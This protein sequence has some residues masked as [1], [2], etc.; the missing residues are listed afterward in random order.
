MTDRLPDHGIC[1]SRRCGAVAA[2]PVRARREGII[3]LSDTAVAT[4]AIA[5]SDP[6]RSP[7]ESTPDTLLHTAA[8][9][10]VREGQMQVGLDAGHTAVRAVGRVAHRST[11]VESRRAPR[12]RE[13]A[14]RPEA[15]VSRNSCKARRNRDPAVPS[16]KQ[17]VTRS[18]RLAPSSEPVRA[19][20][21]AR[22][23]AIVW[24]TAEPW[25]LMLPG[26]CADATHRNRKRCAKAFGLRTP[27]SPS[28]GRAAFGTRSH[29]LF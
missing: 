29:R 4:R 6:P 7:D 15:E 21:T 22:C 9:P 11:A 3:Q 24:R 27:P 12:R 20:G 26:L 8:N 25:A 1:G 2:R 10:V 28:L 13:A 17:R 16:C 23:L 5:S 19:H 14:Y 18:I